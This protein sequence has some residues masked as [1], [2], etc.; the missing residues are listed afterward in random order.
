MDNDFYFAP[1][2]QYYSSGI[3]VGISYL[4]SQ[5]KPYYPFSGEAKPTLKNITHWK[6]KQ[7]LYSP[8]DINNVIFDRMDRPFAGLFTISYSKSWL[9]ATRGWHREIEIGLIGPWSQV[10]RFQK[11]WHR[12]FNMDEPLLWEFQ[13]KNS[14]ALIWRETWMVRSV[15]LAQGD[16]LSNTTVE[17]GTIFNTIKQEYQLRWGKVQSLEQS[18]ATGSLLGANRLKTRSAFEDYVFISQGLKGVA[19]NATI[20]G[21]IWGSNTAATD[22]VK[23]LVYESKLGYTLAYTNWDLSGIFVLQSP[24][25]EKAEW[26]RYIRLNW[27]YRF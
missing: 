17:V 12:F 11:S 27:S 23:R 5:S 4:T 18:T 8:S 25:N 14:P 20:Q 19:Y 1:Q 6:I 13:I 21:R 9:L 16:V 3:F 2:D 22:K 10:E 7:Y 26:H 15:K 24:E